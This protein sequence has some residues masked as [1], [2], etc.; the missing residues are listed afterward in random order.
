MFNPG[1]TISKHQSEI[2][3]Q[4]L[5]NASQ[6]PKKQGM[7]GITNAKLGKKITRRTFDI[8]KKKLLS[9][10]QILQVF[11][12]KHGDQIWKYYDITFFGFLSL[13]NSKKSHSLEKIH[14][15]RFLPA[16][17]RHWEKLK[18]IY[19]E[20][21]LLDFLKQ[22]L[23]SLT[24][25]TSSY[26]DVPGGS[27]RIALK[28][29]IELGILDSEILLKNYHPVK[30]GVSIKRNKELI[31]RIQASLYF[32]FYFSIFIQRIT[33][34]HKN[35]VTVTQLFVD[36][37]GKDEASTAIQK[38]N[39]S[40]VKKMNKIIKIIKKDKKLNAIFLKYLNQI[41]DKFDK[42]KVIAFLESEFCR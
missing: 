8:N 34:N 23:S 26:V 7:R 22:S 10:W 16:I 27:S 31:L 39:K 41:L 36:F 17:Y 33:I 30:H 32:L 14:L 29:I 1:A 12:K 21:S 5:E 25:S 37:S 28:E 18:L 11:K 2:L 42:P 40:A 13:C 20:S 3:L 15:Q 24:Y 19:P 9:N 35:G 4:I 38:R 6:I